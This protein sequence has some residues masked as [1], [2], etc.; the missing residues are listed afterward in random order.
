VVPVGTIKP[1]GEAAGAV[2]LV[3]VVVVLVEV[4]KSTVLEVLVLVLVVAGWVLVATVV[5]VVVAKVVMS[6]VWMGRE[7]LELELAG[8]WVVVTELEV[9]VV[10]AAATDDGDGH[11]YDQLEELV[12]AVLLVW[13]LLAGMVLE[14]LED[15]ALDDI[16]ELEESVLDDTDKVAD[17]DGQGYDQDPTL[18]D[19][20]VVCVCVEEAGT[21]VVGCV[22]VEEADTVV[23]VTCVVGTWIELLEATEDEETTDEEDEG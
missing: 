6:S 2:V 8:A 9:L 5:E 20:I 13:V 21:V 18:L 1:D 4:G 3:E 12:A 23:V 15:E 16:E 17:G 7:E 11:G 14:E 22:C 10:L 19:K